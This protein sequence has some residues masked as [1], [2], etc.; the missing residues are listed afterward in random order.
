M[1]DLEKCVTVVLFRRRRMSIGERR[2]LEGEEE[3]GKERER[4][5]KGKYL[6]QQKSPQLL[7]WACNQ[8][9]RGKMLAS[10]DSTDLCFTWVLGLL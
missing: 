10:G 5:G 8:P 3:K 6:L 4:L 9:C 7:P 2:K 1:I